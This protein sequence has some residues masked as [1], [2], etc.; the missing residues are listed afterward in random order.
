M[1]FLY[2]LLFTLGVIL[3]APYY[4]WRLRGRITSA[5]DW[6]ERLGFLPKEFQ[7]PRRGAIWIH[8]VSVGEAIAILGL[9]REI[10]QRYPERKIFVSN[11]TPAGGETIQSR[12]SGIAGRFLLPLDWSI[13]A[14][15]TVN[16][17]RPEVLVIVETELWPNLIR[18]AHA[19]GARVLVVNGRISDRSFPRYRVVRSFMRGVLEMVDGIAAQSEVDA[20]RFRTLGAPEG[21]VAVAGNL[22]FD[23]QPP[24]LNEF[25]Q[26]LRKALQEAERSPIVVA[27]STMPGEEDLLLPAWTEIR[28]RYPQA[29]LILAPRHPARFDGVAELLTESGANFTRRTTLGSGGRQLVSQIAPAEI[30]LVDTIGELA[31]LFELADIV[32]MGGSLVPTGG[33][34]VLEPA[35]WGKPVLFGPHMHNFRDIAQL[36]LR[37]DAAIQIPN[38]ETL[39]GIM[40]QLLDDPRRREQL[41]KAAKQLLGEHRGATQRVLTILAEWLGEP[42]AASRA[43]ERET[44]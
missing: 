29:L 36:F 35:Y 25:T 38:A 10:Q 24:Q 23:A 2:S 43:V 8:A 32:F 6:R 41:G 20:R 16:R 27:A 40:V 9:A 5:S 28:R 3:T 18:A 39:A 17:I 22:K 14:R 19:S 7:Q 42:V 31:S 26:L 11:V 37:R 30:L 4:L 44:V 33:H 34:N 1:F 12:L 13:C 15:R 21:R